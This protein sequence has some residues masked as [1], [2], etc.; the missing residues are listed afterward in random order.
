MPDG[1]PPEVARA[2]KAEMVLDT[3][4]QGNHISIKNTSFVEML[5]AGRQPDL[6]VKQAHSH[7]A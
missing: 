3:T 2:G 5:P 7:T 1:L 4:P 6:P